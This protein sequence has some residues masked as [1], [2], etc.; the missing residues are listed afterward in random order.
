MR[1]LR[2]LVLSVLVACIIGL[3]S[4]M[5]GC[6]PARVAND[7]TRAGVI[8]LAGATRV[9][10]KV[11]EAKVFEARDNPEL[12]EAEVL[13]AVAL[14]DTCDDGIS[15]ALEALEEGAA[16]VDQNI[17][18]G[19]ACSSLRASAALTAVVVA[20]RNYGAVIPW[21]VSQAMR[22]GDVAGAYC[23]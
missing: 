13:Q 3:A 16:A 9:I 23:K 22:V 10:Y 19:A 1:F 6:V 12:T 5:S 21:S 11:C 14:A 15:T 17:V 18:K 8:S 4:C 2:D 7:A 20:L